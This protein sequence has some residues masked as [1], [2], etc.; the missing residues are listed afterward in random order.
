MTLNSG[1]VH[2]TCGMISTKVYDSQEVKETLAIKWIIKP[3]LI[4]ILVS[5]IESNAYV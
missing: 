2:I 4:D 1:A 5:N 3:S